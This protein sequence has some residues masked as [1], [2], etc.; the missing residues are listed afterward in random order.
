M[1]SR[2]LVLRSFAPPLP[3]STT[4]LAISS[5]TTE[6]FYSRAEQPKGFDASKF[7]NPGR[8]WSQAAPVTY[9]LQLHTPVV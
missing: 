6:E 4:S 5:D 1:S 2:G 8:H 3:L 7:W 9:C